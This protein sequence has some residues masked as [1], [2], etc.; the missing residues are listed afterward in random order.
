[1]A[2]QAKRIYGIKGEIIGVIQ[3]AQ[4]ITERKRAE[5]AIRESQRQL[6]DIIEFLPDATLVIDKDGK[7]IA[8]NRAIE[9]MTGVKAEE[10]LG[11]GDYEYTLPFYGERH[12]ILID[13]ALHPDP[14]REKQ[15]YTSIRRTGDIL[16]GE[17]Y[18]PKLS[19]GNVHLSATASVLRDSRGEIIA[20]IE[21]IRNNTERR[22]LEEQLQQAQ[23]MEAVGTLAGGI[24][25]D[26]NNLL[27]GIL[28]HA[29]VMISDLQPNHPFYT[30]LKGIEQFVQ[31]GAGLT[32]QLLGFASKGAYNVRPTDINELMD[33]TAT[34]FG[35]TR[36]EITIHLDFQEDLWVS[37]VD[38][39]QM[40]QVLMNLFVNAW[41]AMPGGGNLY[42]ETSNY[43]VNPE[44]L[45]H[46]VLS[47]GRYVKISV[48]DTGTGMDEKTMEKIFDPFF[49]TKEM[50][51]GTGL[52]LATVYG[53]IKTHGGHITVYSQ[54]GRGST[55]NIYLPASDKEVDREMVPPAELRRGTETI[56]LVDDEDEI[57]EVMKDILGMLGHEV[58]D[59]ADG[60]TAVELYRVHGDRIKLVILDMVMPGM[61][62]GQV[63]D[64]LKNLNP[65]VKVLLSSGYSIN[66]EAKTIIERGCRGFIQKPVSFT[67]LSQKIG[68]VLDK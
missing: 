32:R 62:G 26:F 21:C 64:R 59:A 57:R 42:L 67:L 33:R 11:K 25:H 65:D 8:W 7:V 30:R 6:A 5:E 68:E 22:R 46:A 48:T 55:F 13:L 20:A 10:M 35:R 43:A 61:S 47:P 51:R 31:S 29:A 63:F 50:G 14:E 19:P 39:T 37:E 60:E 3:T 17:A 27:T 56:L 58:L 44:D 40:E 2:I 53:I 49:T 34:M 54:A 9:A 23:K 24:A 16:F 28:G 12:P 4:D 15:Q 52:G 36:K 45:K 66:G 38:M 1:M 41:Q 18:T